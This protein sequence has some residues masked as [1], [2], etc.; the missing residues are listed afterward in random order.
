MSKFFFIT[1]GGAGIGAAIAEAAVARGHRV[2]L[3]DQAGDKAAAL[4]ARL[5]SQASAHT[6]DVTDEAQVEAALDAQG[7][8]PDALINNAGI[9]QFAPLIDMPA[10]DFRRIMEID[11]N[12]A[13]IVARACARRMI[14]RGSGSITNITSTGGIA[15]SPG[16][17]AYAPAKAGLAALTRLMALEWGPLGVRVNALAPGMIDGGVSEPIYRDAKVRE[18]RAGAVPLRRLG[19]LEDI[20]AAALFM[21]S[22]EAAYMN[23]HEM[24]VDGGLTQAVMSMIPRAY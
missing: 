6:G 23:G 10:A 22:D 2:A 21:A 19:R 7:A 9:V 20:A 15:V 13:F 8:V 5:G 1:G 11:L 18:T 14:A 12:G 3:F 17:N 16:T 24:V 4:A